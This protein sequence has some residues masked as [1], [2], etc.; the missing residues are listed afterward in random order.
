MRAIRYLAALTFFALAIGCGPSE[1]TLLLN[2]LPAPGLRVATL[3]A[4][5]NIGGSLVA[6]QSLASNNGVVELPGSVVI[7]LPD[8]STDVNVVLTGATVDGQPLHASVT[9]HSVPHAQVTGVVTLGGSGSESNGPSGSDSGS[10]SN[11]SPADMATPPTPAHD[12]AMST[13]DLAMPP[14]L[15][16]PPVV[17]LAKDDFNRPDQT[18]WGKA[19]D[20]QTWG[21]DANTSNTFSIKNK[22]GQITD[23]NGNNDTGT[24]GPVSTNVDVL[25]T[26]SLASF[27]N[28]SEI[29]P[30]ARFNDN[31][32]FYKAV[33]N[34]DIFKIVS[35][36][37]GTS[38]DLVTVNFAATAGTLYSIRFR[39]SG[40]SL[41]AKVWPAAATEPAGWML[42]TS[43]AN[44][45]SGYC[46]VR[47][48]FDANTTATFT[49]FVALPL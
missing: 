21:T 11:D 28:N 8:E 15:A 5:L 4:D 33:I 18:F 10:G 24:L 2:V 49:S 14:D 7:L 31:G 45:A 37:K 34:G 20:G 36:V 39:V 19:S 17:P 6:S 13:P 40:T 32:N 29:G 35:K 26:G 12:M 41:M 47:L 38:T 43:D 46:G 44:I 16:P 25:A 9:Y 48:V 22:T 27:N 23:V 30:T 42:N 3:Q 1:T